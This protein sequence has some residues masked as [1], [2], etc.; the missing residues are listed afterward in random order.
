M[1]DLSVSKGL[2]QLSQR[3]AHRGKVLEY[4]CWRE[5]GNVI[6]GEVN[7]GF[8]ERNQLHELLLD[9][10]QAAGNDDFVNPRTMWGRAPPPVRLSRRLSKHCRLSRSSGKSVRPFDR[11]TAGFAR[12]DKLSKHRTRWLKIMLQA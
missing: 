8:E 1:N 3:L 9:G 11:L 7:S 4:L 10:L 2:C 5:H 12:F 6:L